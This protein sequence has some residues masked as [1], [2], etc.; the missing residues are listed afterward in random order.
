[1]LCD[2]YSGG[3]VVTV[4][5]SHLN[6]VAEPHTTVTVVVNRLLNDTNITSSKNETDSPV[7]EHHFVIFLHHNCHHPLLLPMRGEKKTRRMGDLNLTR[8]TIT[9][10]L[11]PNLSNYQSYQDHI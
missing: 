8:R 1:M 3:T 2:V 6:S 9:D 5:G 4:F 11:S 7:T 10:G